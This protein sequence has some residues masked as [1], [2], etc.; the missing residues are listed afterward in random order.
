MAEGDLYWVFLESFCTSTVWRKWRSILFTAAFQSPP[1][2]GARGG[3]VTYTI[4]FWEKLKI[5]SLVSFAE[6]WMYLDDIV[7]GAKKISSIIA[8]DLF[9]TSRLQLKHFSANMQES[10]KSRTISKWIAFCGKRKNGYISLVVWLRGNRDCQV[11]F[12]V[13]ERARCRYGLGC[14][15]SHNL[16]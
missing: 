6:K 15:I 8:K 1:K 5:E 10:S 7:P 9:V 3:M 2:R 16:G 11:D 12:R 4:H 13:A 14:Q